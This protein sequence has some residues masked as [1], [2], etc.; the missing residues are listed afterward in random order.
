MARIFIDLPERFSFSTEIPLYYLHIN[1][2]GH[3]DNAML[4]TL[5]SEARARFFIASGYRQEDVEGLA[6]LTG[7]LAVQYLSEAHYGDVM[8]VEMGARDFNRHGCDLVFRMSDKASGREV[9]R[10]KLGLVFYDKLAKKVALV[11]PAF[12]ARLTQ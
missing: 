4:L 6:T 1:A 11:P 3:L 9:A 10:G 7:D 2:A 8:V 5:V 12:K